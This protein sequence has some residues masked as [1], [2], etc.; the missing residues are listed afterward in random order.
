MRSRRPETHE[1]FI[2]MAEKLGGE[3]VQ[4]A[5]Y[6]VK[7]G[8]LQARVVLCRDGQEISLNCAASDAIVLATKK[9]VPIAVAD[10]IVEVAGFIPEASLGEGASSQSNGK[11]ERLRAFRD[12]IEEL[13][14]TGIGGPT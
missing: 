7:E 6:Q 13:D 14:V 8:V 2:Q 1:L 5:L 3:L 9:G 12:F 10:E 4:A 11:V